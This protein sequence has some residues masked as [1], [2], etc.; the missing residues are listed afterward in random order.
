ML[1][2][3]STNG[4][5]YLKAYREEY[6]DDFA[7]VADEIHI[8]D[9]IIFGQL[10]HPG[11]EETGDWGMT[12]QLAPSPSPS[13]ADE[14]PKRIEPHEIARIRNAFAASA[15]NLTD[16]GFDGIEIAANAFS[17]VQ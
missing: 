6:V 17:I 10:T 4:P 3:P 5:S 1:A 11:G 9:S 14:M 15:V 12:E 7:D 8:A 2:H 16:A 13:D